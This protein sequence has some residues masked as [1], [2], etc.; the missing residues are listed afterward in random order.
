MSIKLSDI[1]KESLKETLPFATNNEAID[2]IL[3]DVIINPNSDKTAMDNRS[4]WIVQNVKSMLNS[5]STTTS[6]EAVT[7]GLIVNITPIYNDS[8]L[9]VIV[10]GTIQFE[11]DSSSSALGQFIH[12]KRNGVQIGPVISNFI[13]LAST[14]HWGSNS[15]VRNSL[16]LCV[17]FLVSSLN[18]KEFEL[19]HE[20]QS[21]T[22]SRIL[23]NTTMIVKE[24]RQ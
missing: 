11:R 24:Y 19:F 1:K 9:E 18:N 6:T 2:G 8:I 15:T 12:I 7:T 3:T 20:S 14:S 16:Y 21:G 17:N 22:L 23:E 4:W 10:H 13:R 5:D